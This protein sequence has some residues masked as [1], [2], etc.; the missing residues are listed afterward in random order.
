MKNTNE[1]KG[2]ATR[3]SLWAQGKGV[4][5]ASPAW[6]TRIA[7]HIATA[8]NPKLI[9]RFIREYKIDY[10]KA[11]RCNDGDTP[12]SCAVKYGTLNE[13][14]TRRIKG[15]RVDPGA[16]V[17]PATCKAVVFD[18]FGG[19][20]IWVKGRMWSAPRL[21]G[22]NVSFNDFAV[23]IFRLRPA[24]YHRFHIPVSGTITNIRHITGKYLSVDPSIVSKQNV[25][26]ENNRVV[27]EIDRGTCYLVAV[28]AAGVGHV[29]IDRNIGSV[30]RPGEPLGSF[31]FGGS[32]VV[33]LVRGIRFDRALAAESA[34][35]RE[36]FI[37][38]G[39]RVSDR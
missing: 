39:T 8:K 23:G 21:L 19:S 33:V 5:G 28:G 1:Y 7:R 20:R 32:T 24:D 29:N 16:V 2:L 34:R 9:E 36:T 25:F 12:R 11:E 17:S 38:V 35:G 18:S 13:F 22:Q 4:H 14:F 15:I 37:N 27:V 30:V 10:K 31:D 6:L 3:V 26:T